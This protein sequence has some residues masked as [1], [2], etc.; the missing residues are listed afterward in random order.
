MSGYRIV[1]G[2]IWAVIAV[3]LGA[4]GLAELTID[5]VSGAV[6]CLAIAIPAGW[7]DYRIWTVKARRLLLIL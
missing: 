5:N 6:V 1:C 4:G 3:G 7:Y 2:M